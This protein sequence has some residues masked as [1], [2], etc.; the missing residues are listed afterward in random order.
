[1]DDL[2][3]AIADLERLGREAPDAIVDELQQLVCGY[4]RAQQQQTPL[5]LVAA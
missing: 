3:G 1:V 4:R 5:Q 2:R